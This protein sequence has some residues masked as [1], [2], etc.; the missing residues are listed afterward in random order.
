MICRRKRYEEDEE[1]QQQEE[2]EEEKNE[3]LFIYSFCPFDDLI[4]YLLLAFLPLAF[5]V[6]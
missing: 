6:F 3:V 2:K 4:V 5:A 1:Q